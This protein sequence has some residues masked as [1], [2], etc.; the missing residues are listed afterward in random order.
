[1]FNRTIAL[2]G[3]RNTR[4]LGG[5]TTTTG[6]LTKSGVFFRSDSIANLTFNDY[7]RLKRKNL[8]TIIDMRTHN[9]RN[10]I[11]LCLIED[12]EINY[13]WVPIELAA[14]NGLCTSLTDVYIDVLDYQH[15]AIKDIFNCLAA[16]KGLCL[17]CCNGGK[18]RTGIISMLLL[19]VADVDINCIIEDYMQTKANMGSTFAK[20]RQLIMENKLDI[21]L[22]GLE[23]LPEFVMDTLN[24]IKQE[25]ASTRNYLNR[26]GVNTSIIIEILGRFISNLE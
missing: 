6:Y 22:N 16:A 5:L 3:T 13:N 9:E 1:M 18:D 23:C 17:F 26:I 2:Q 7:S 8:T 14:R 20:V 24:H 15:N 10:A 19:D 21:P 12:K 25:Y 11:P 4:D